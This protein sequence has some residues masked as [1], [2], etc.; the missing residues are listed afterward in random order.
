MESISEMEKHL[1]TKT[2]GIYKVMS[3]IT[4]IAASL[5]PLR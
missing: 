1:A 3:V 2:I 5:V 4:I